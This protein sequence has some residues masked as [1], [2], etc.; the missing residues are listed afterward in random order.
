[1]ND[2]LILGFS[3]VSIAVSILVVVGSSA[4]SEEMSPKVFTTDYLT[5][6][7]KL[8]A[9]FANCS[10][11]YVESIY[12]SRA[13]GIASQVRRTFAFAQG[14]GLL[15]ETAKDG[16][17]EKKTSADPRKKGLGARFETVT[18][19]NNN[20]SFS[21]VKSD[22]HSAYVLGMLEAG[23]SRG[24]RQIV[25]GFRNP[26]NFFTQVSLT[27]IETI[28]ESKSF[29]VERLSESGQ[30]TDNHRI[31]VDF[32]RPM[33]VTQAN[34]GG[35][36]ITSGWLIVAPEEGWLL[37]EYGVVKTLSAR[38]SVQGTTVGHYE[39]S[40]DFGGEFRPVAYV[41]KRYDQRFNGDVV[42]PGVTPS[43]TENFE[44]LGFRFGDTPARQFTL[45]AFGLP[46][47][48][49]PAARTLNRPYPWWII[50]ISIGMFGIAIVLR[51]LANRPRRSEAGFVA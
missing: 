8:D 1:M 20:Y 2:R 49:D 50:V 36:H 37:H 15:V 32:T 38:P 46:E 41:V 45:T 16:G 25:R 35:A 11:E 43:S 24:R 18:A 51:R 7:K 21:L 33:V 12:L 39:Y 31:R 3:S 30:G 22:P 27:P 44:F 14:A 34:M 4:A 26:S 13:N 29:R 10:G 48:T 19:Y 17:D 9:K 23:P 47:F 28:L 6:L 5:A 40:R 42:D